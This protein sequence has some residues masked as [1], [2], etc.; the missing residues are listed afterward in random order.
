MY[1]YEEMEGRS[2]QGGREEQERESAGIVVGAA[3]DG[4]NQSE[5]CLLFNFS[6]LRLSSSHTLSNRAMAARR[7]PS[8]PQ[9]RRNLLLFPTESFFE[10][11]QRI[12][13]N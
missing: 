10:R 5:S 1:A 9:G 7:C 8:E 12:T 6:L 2:K 11:E 4:I 13:G 3:A